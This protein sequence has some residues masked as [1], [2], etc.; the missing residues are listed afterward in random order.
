M[1]ISIKYCALQQACILHR[2]NAGQE[3]AEKGTALGSSGPAWTGEQSFS[4]TCPSVATL[5][6]IT[7]VSPH[8][9]YFP[10]GSAQPGWPAGMELR[11]WMLLLPAQIVIAGIF[12]PGCWKVAAV[13]WQDDAACSQREAGGVARRSWGRCAK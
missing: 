11:S 2:L 7:R 8:S 5:A 13:P 9:R 12:L 10:A 1:L 6:C 4:C 3:R